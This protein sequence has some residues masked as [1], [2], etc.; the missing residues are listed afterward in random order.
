MVSTRSIYFDTIKDVALK[1]RLQRKLKN[2]SFI[3]R[4]FIDTGTQSTINFLSFIVL[5]L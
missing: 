3:H 1:K 5:Y 4:S 2:R